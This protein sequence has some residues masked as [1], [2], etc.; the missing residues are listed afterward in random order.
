MNT[1]AY[2]NALS[3]ISKELIKANPNN[4]NECI[5]Q[6]F[7]VANLAYE[8]QIFTALH[9]ETELWSE[10]Q[11]LKFFDILRNNQCLK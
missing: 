8:A 4:P 6:A 10:E 9:S 3:K 7:N 11:W 2:Q 5:D 1:P